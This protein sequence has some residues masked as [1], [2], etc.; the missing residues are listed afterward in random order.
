[1][2]KKK[3]IEVV[4]AT[5]FEKGDAVALESGVAVPIES[6]DELPTYEGVQVIAIIEKN[7]NDL[8]NHCAMA[9]GT[10]KHVP[11]ELFK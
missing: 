4:A 11:I 6:T 10:T 1:M 8:F 2:A 3:I 9:D 5:D 7:V